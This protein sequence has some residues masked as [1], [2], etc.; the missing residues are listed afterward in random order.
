[1]RQLNQNEISFLKRNCTKMFLKDIAKEFNVKP[2][3]LTYFCKKNKIHGRAKK[4]AWNS[5]HS[6]LRKDVLTYFMGHSFEETQKTFKLSK[7]ELKSLFAAAYRDKTLLHL[8]KDSRTKEPFDIKTT[9]K[10]VKMLGL[11][12]RKDVAI[13]LKRGKT[14]YVVRD[15]LKKMNAEETRYLNGISERW[16]KQ[17]FGISNVGIK[18]KACPKNFESIIIPWVDLEYRLSKM[19][20]DDTL[21]RCV[22]SMARFQRWIYNSNSRHYII[23]QIKKVI[24]DSTPK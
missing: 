17:L 11:I 21:A 2:A 5:K 19:D 24:N 16:A 13:K 20:V 12:S 15:R 8:R 18:T 6:H 14:H 3:A 4:G 22:K 10:M 23:K 7:S 9:I 1:M